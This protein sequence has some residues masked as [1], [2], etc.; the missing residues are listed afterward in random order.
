M[1]Q[2]PL[3]IAVLVLVQIVPVGAEV[4]QGT[5]SWYSRASC[6]VEGSSGVMANGQALDDAAFTVA[7]WDY[8]FGTTLRICRR[9][10]G[11]DRQ[12]GCVDV[13]VTDRGPAKRLYRQGRLVDLSR[14]A[15]M[16]LGP[17]STGVIPVTIQVLP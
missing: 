14:T 15:F 6:R 8:P 17:L 2:R 12:L 16:A 13:R 7:S 5:A 3:A 1:T 9:I 10:H 11:Q 4:R